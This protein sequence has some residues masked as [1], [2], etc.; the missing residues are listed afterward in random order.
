M[1][2]A[3]CTAATDRD[4]APST[5]ALSP[6]TTGADAASS[7]APGAAGSSSWCSVTLP[8][9]DNPPGQTSRFSYGNGRLWVE[10][11]PRGVIRTRNGTPRPDGS[12]A[13][14][15]PWTR[16]VRGRLVITGRRLDAAAPPLRSWV[17]TGYGRT[18]FQSSAVIFPTEGCW[19]VTGRAG[20]IELTIV[21]RVAASAHG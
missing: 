10:L 17:P 21:A 1:L 13:V 8:N 9:G 4:P 20:V 12:L 6:S 14:K 3:S 5:T 19:E 2:C 15:F 7:D 18:G 16:G 11:Y